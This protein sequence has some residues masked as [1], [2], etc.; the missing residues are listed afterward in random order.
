MRTSKRSLI[1]VA[2]L[3]LVFLAG[4]GAAKV[5]DRRAST[6][7]AQGQADRYRQVITDLERDYYKPLDVAK[8]GQKGITALL[9]SLHDPYTVYFTPQQAKQFQQE[10]S[11]SY[12]G[13]GVAVDVK[14]GRLTVTR[15]FPGSP[16]ASAGISPGEVI[17]SVD[18]K[19]TAGQVPPARPSVCSC[20]RPRGRAACRSR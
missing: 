12:T 15:V 13:V 5:L 14:S 19:P 3:V 4:F 10:L 16:A 9:A 6:A 20:A 1:A 7:T 18:G 11:G 17:V 8:L 2:I